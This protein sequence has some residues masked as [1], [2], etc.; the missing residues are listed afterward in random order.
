MVLKI[1]RKHLDEIFMH[2][3]ENYPIEAC[4]I[5]AGEKSGAE[6]IV[7]KV[8]HTRNLVASPSAYQIDPLE[9]LK[10]FEEAELEG[11]DVVGFYHSHPFW[12]AFWSEADEMGSKHWVGYSYLIVSLKTG[13]FCAYVRKEEDVEVE[14]VVVI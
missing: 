11:L 8:Y 2:A 9:Q 6:K 10:V 12:D 3:K 4:G 5:L 7:R 1:S 14:E 13:G